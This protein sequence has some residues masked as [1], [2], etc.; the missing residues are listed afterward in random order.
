MLRPLAPVLW[1]VR[2]DFVQHRSLVDSIHALTKAVR[3]RWHRDLALLKALHLV[4]MLSSS[5]SVSLSRIL[6]RSFVRAFV[7][8]SIGPGAAGAAVVM[9]ESCRAL[10]DYDAQDANELTFKAGSIVG[11]VCIFLHIINS[12]CS[13]SID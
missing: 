11:L 12:G 7:D 13:L 8:R 2:V 10:Y 4:P 3:Q 9:R 6:N 1:Q 5:S